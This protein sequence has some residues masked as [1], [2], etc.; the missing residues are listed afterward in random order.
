ML[1]CVNLNVESSKLQSW[2]VK[3]T[4]S[5]RQMELRNWKLEC[6]IADVGTNCKSRTSNAK[7]TRKIQTLNFGGHWTPYLN[8]VG[9]TGFG[10]SAL[11]LLSLDPS[12][13]FTVAVEPEKLDQLETVGNKFINIWTAKENVVS[14]L[15]WQRHQEFFSLRP[16]VVFFEAALK[17]YWYNQI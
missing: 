2:I 6:S 5:N 16:K 3:R 9:P 10:T 15:K 17:R 1:N 8:D 4:M 7:N 11:S 12:C 14:A 13:S